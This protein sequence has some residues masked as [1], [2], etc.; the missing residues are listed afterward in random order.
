[1]QFSFFIFY[2]R[3]IIVSFIFI[4]ELNVLVSSWNEIFKVSKAN[5]ENEWNY[6]VECKRDPYRSEMLMNRLLQK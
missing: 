6:R 4:F 2:K 5:A 3:D 1:M